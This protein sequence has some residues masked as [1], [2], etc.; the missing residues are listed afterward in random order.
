MPKK[1][2]K[3]VIKR[4]FNKLGNLFYD[5]SG[6]Y[7]MEDV[8]TPLKSATIN[9]VSRKKIEAQLNKIL[10]MPGMQAII[11]GKDDCGKT[12]FVRATLKEKDI[13][14][15]TTT[16]MD[17]NTI[18]DLIISAIDQ[19]NPF[20]PVEKISSGGFEFSTEFKAKYVAMEASVKSNWKSE[21][22]EK[23]KRLHAP[24]ISIQWLAEMFGMEGIVWVIDDVH[25]INLQERQKFVEIFSVF[26]NKSNIY[27]STKIIVIGDANSGQGLISFSKN[28]ANFISEIEV[29][30]LTLDEIRCIIKNGERLLNIEFDEHI[31]EIISQLSLHNPA[32]CHRFCFNICYE[33]EITQTQ[34]NT[35]MITSGLVNN[36][37]IAYLLQDPKRYN[38]IFE[39]AL[40]KINLN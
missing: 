21:I 34:S 14:F 25:K 11:Y 27:P 29:P 30:I 36:I 5:T 19:V 39:Q 33:H 28:V 7:R 38:E 2:W 8:F 37:I 1:I 17:N 23:Q 13:K 32:N 10:L 20:Y 9:Y 4:S 6:D 16:C 31:N 24:K 22:H 26:N 15:I 12:T 3:K 40:K 18:D 35:K